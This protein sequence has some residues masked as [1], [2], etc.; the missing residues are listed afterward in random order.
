MNS[1][2]P[3]KRLLQTAVYTSIL[4]GTLAIAL[5]AIFQSVSVSWFLKIGFTLALFIFIVWLINIVLFHLR[6][7]YSDS[8][9]E[10]IRYISSYIICFTLVVFTRLLL[11]TVIENDNPVEHFVRHNSEIDHHRGALHASFLLGFAL[12]TVVLLIQDLMLLREKKIR[13]ELEN[14]ELKIKNVEATNQQLK[15]QIHPHFLF[16]SLNTLKTLIKK[17]PDKAED[18]LVM[19]S[20]FLRTSISTDIPNVVK[21][22][23]EIKLCNDY[24]KM[25]K[26]R[27]GKAL[28]Y[29][30]N[31]PEEIYNSKYIPVFSLLSLL[32]N[33]I[34]HNVLTNE[35]PLHIKIEK[36]NSRIITTNNIQPKLTPEPSTRSGLENLA[37]RYK[38]LSG[39]EVIV[40]KNENEFSVSIKMLDNENSNHRG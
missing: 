18:Y 38:I 4:I 30:I 13:I 34:K 1:S 35:M 29:T 32:E 19:L 25:Q 36:I 6:E 24:L 37:E 5:H 39:D 7:K 11:R 10:Y 28:Q 9:P 16:N 2:V 40:N 33:A 23:Y 26:M 12:N 20:D 17:N 14:A 27:F 31:I 3:I 15:Q 21:L 8:F 22:K